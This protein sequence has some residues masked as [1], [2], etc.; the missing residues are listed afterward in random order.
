MVK[1]AVAEYGT[2]VQ[3]EFIWL[4]VGPITGY[5]EHGNEPS[6]SIRSGKFND[7]L[8]RVCLE[9]RACS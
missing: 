9:E 7:R 1:R 2:K 4:R 3:A 5:C 6:Q 8:R